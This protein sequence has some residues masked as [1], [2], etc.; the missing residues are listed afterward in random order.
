MIDAVV[1][2]PKPKRRGNR[3][4]TS[5]D[6]KI[7]VEK[8]LNDKGINFNAQPK[9]S[10]TYYHLDE[11]VFNP[12]HNSGEVAIIQNS[13]GKTSYKC[14]HASCDDN[15][16]AQF[17]EQVGVDTPRGVRTHRPREH[18]QPPHR[19]GDETGDPDFIVDDVAIESP[20]NAFG[21]GQWMG[22]VETMNNCRFSYERNTRSWYQATQTHWAS[23][24]WEHVRQEVQYSHLKK[25]GRWAGGMYIEEKLEKRELISILD[26]WFVGTHFRDGMEH[27]LDRELPPPPVS[28][29][30]TKSGIVQIEPG[31]ITLRP[32]NPTS[33]SFKS[34]SP[35]HITTD[36]L[37]DTSTNQWTDTLDDWFQDAE[38]QAYAQLMLGASLICQMKRKYILLIGPSGSGKTTFSTCV[39][40]SIG[41]L[42]ANIGK[43][44]FAENKSHNDQLCD[45]IEHQTRICVFPEAANTRLQADII[46]RL[47]GGEYHQSRRAYGKG[48]VSGAIVATPLIV[49]ETVPSLQGLTRGTVDRQVV[50]RFNDNPNRSINEKLLLDSN[51]ATSEL[52]K[53]C[54]QWLIQGAARFL[55]QGLPEPPTAIKDESEAA[56]AE[57]NPLAAWAMECSNAG[58]WHDNGV[59]AQE[60]LNVYLEHIGEENNQD[61][62]KE[63]KLTASSVG[64]LLG[65]IAWTRKRDG[66]HY[67]WFPPQLA[68]DAPQPQQIELPEAP[69]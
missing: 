13:D 9:G 37:N 53:Y 68:D 56:V 8:I 22:K 33:D 43:D 4:T 19:E 32:F 57:Q 41:N 51:T 67:R 20:V 47:T 15:H 54:F 12:E 31:T 17:K 26:R 29:L 45:L 69:F 7:D 65:R 30:A 6:T 35:T 24:D 50:V 55:E 66:N 16:W 39:L 60:L 1:P 25:L 61:F 21:I 28:Q 42:G 64:R 63:S 14:F 10:T 58:L 3:H 18:T 40:T 59:L 23:I 62:L 49:S 46:N 36:Q 38:S 52:V 5:S 2:K 44:L 34:L 27:T 48:L 11:C